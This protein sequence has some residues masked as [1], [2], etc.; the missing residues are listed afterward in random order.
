MCDCRLYNMY[1]G[2]Q[3]IQVAKVIKIDKIQT[4]ERGLWQDHS[5]WYHKKLYLNYEKIKKINITNVKNDI[6]F[7]YC[8]TTYAEHNNRFKSSYSPKGTIQRDSA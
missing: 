4:K 7:E 5:M 2:G 6:D 8:P 1:S 3:C